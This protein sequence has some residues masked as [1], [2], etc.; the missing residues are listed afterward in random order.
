MLLGGAEVRRHRA[1]QDLALV[2]EAEARAAQEQL[3][4]EVRLQ[5]AAAL[6]QRTEQLELAVPRFGREE[7]QRLEDLGRGELGL[8]PLD[9]TALGVEDGD[10]ARAAE[11]VDD[12]ALARELR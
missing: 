6:E 10:V 4:E 9:A 12:L 3:G 1:R 2:V 8:A 11:P 5:P 7:A